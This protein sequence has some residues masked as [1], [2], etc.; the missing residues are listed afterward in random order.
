MQERPTLWPYAAFTW[1]VAWLSLPALPTYLPIPGH[2][3]WSRL[4]A[5]TVIPALICFFGVIGDAIT[6]RSFAIALINTGIL[7]E[8]LYVTHFV[9]M[10]TALQ[11]VER[12]L[13]ALMALVSLVVCFRSYRPNAPPAMEILSSGALTLAFIARPIWADAF[14]SS[15]LAVTLG[16]LAR[17]KSRPT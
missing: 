8:S 11:L 15:V 16:V 12:W 17:R 13:A 7:I 4:A 14:S 6:R 5:M 1:V 3:L 9:S 2:F 10:P